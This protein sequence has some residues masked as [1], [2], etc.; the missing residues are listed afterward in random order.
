MRNSLSA[1]GLSMSE[2]QSIS[3]I[4]NQKALDISNTISVI[5]NFERIIKVDGETY[6]E[7]E[8]NPIPHNIV[9]LITNKARYHATQAFLMENVKAKDAMIEALKKEVFHYDVPSPS[10]GDTEKANLLPEV[11][12]DWAR[13]QLTLDEVNDYLSNEAQAAHI[14]QFIHNRSK[15]DSLRKELP[16]LSKLDWVTVKEGEKTPVV[17]KAHHTQEELTAF[18]EEFSALHRDAESKVNWIKAKMNNLITAE[19]ARIAEVNA[20]EIERV[21]LLNQATRQVYADASTKWRDDY[22]KA[23]TEFEAIRNKKIK[24]RWR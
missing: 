14:G 16:T 3:N 18:Y 7:T 10:M 23:S 13:A 12:H 8:G 1:K 2:A 5:N 4:C 21:N 20:A 24:F 17:I 11:T 6:V 9:E 22:K 15:L 19:N